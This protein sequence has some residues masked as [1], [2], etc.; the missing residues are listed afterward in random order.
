MPLLN[1]KI[2]QD[3]ISKSK[4]NVDPNAK[5]G[6]K[7]LFQETLTRIETGKFKSGRGLPVG[8]ASLAPFGKE[9]SEKVPFLQ[10]LFEL[11]GYKLHENLE[12]E[13]STQG[14]SIE[15]VLS[16]QKEKGGDVEVW[17]SEDKI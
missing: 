4:H 3:N 5:Q 13:F 11:L 17:E 12:F 16:L 1:R 15:G 7:N 8:K 2:L 9:E 10:R 14:R 6:L